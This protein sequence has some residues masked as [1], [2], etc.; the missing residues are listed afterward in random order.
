MK[1]YNINGIFDTMTGSRL[2]G[3][4]ISELRNPFDFNEGK[5]IVK[6]FIDARFERRRN[7]N[8]IKLKIFISF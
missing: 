1:Y 5:N 8:D 4:R 3:K 6:N 2:P 7:P